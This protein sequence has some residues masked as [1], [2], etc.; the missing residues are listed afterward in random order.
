MSLKKKKPKTLLDQLAISGGCFFAGIICLMYGSTF[1]GQLLGTGSAEIGRNSAYVTVTGRDAQININFFWIGAVVFILAAL[2]NLIVT[3]RREFNNPLPFDDF[4]TFV[5]CPK[6]VEPLWG[7]DN[8]SMV[9]TKCQ[10]PLE[11]VR[12]FYDKH[13]ELKTTVKENESSIEEGKFK[14]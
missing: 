13:P 5:I 4:N 10:S 2:I 7:N 14:E 6:C 11:N 9:C 1:Q 3:A 8:P 12:G